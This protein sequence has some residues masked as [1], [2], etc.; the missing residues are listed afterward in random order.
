MKC[1][2]L[3]ASA[4]L[5]QFKL[6]AKPVKSVL[7]RRCAVFVL[8]MTHFL[9]PNL[10]TAQEVIL[11]SAE[12]AAL[13]ISQRQEGAQSIVSNKV[14]RFVGDVIVKARS[15]QGV[16]P[17]NNILVSGNTPAGGVSDFFAL[18][19]GGRPFVHQYY[20]GDLVATDDSTEA[21]FLLG[22][23]SN[24]GMAEVAAMTE[25]KFSDRS[26]PS[27]NIELVSGR[28]RLWIQKE[29]EKGFTV[30]VADHLVV[31][32]GIAQAFIETNGGDARISV[33]EGAVDIS[34]FSMTEKNRKLVLEAQQAV[35]ISNKRLDS[36][37]GPPSGA[38]SD[39]A[40]FPPEENLMAF[41]LP[42]FLGDH[43]N[44]NVSQSFVNGKVG[45]L[46]AFETR[47]FR[48]EHSSIWVD[49]GRIGR[50]HDTSL[51][52]NGVIRFIAPVA[53]DFRSQNSI[54]GSISL[55]WSVLAA[56]KKFSKQRSA[57]Q[58][59]GQ[60]LRVLQFRM[61]SKHVSAVWVD[62]MIGNSSGRFEMPVLVQDGEWQTLRVPIKESGLSL[63]RE[64][65][66]EIDRR[67]S[68]LMRH[69][70]Q[71][72]LDKPVEQIAVEIRD[73]EILHCMPGAYPAE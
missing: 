20:K 56:G 54:L 52:E 34:G 62:Q 38:G 73:F 45:R 7:V 51:T 11:P 3:S 50:S 53:E 66:P 29:V 72:N 31:A 46:N 43:K 19:F 8:H 61:R 30:K 71:T 17:V 6:G 1:I 13:L 12:R 18:G 24:I 63:S 65:K 10:S 37:I 44:Q 60:Y 27:S 16:T 58:V 47:S 48:A 26:E 55:R 21:T 49:T 9:V 22:D 57:Q 33:H 40:R 41:L 25:L 68:L 64:M 39:S 14:S 35:T 15:A 59:D 28:L 2:L 5:Q 4:T 69:R 23:E 67:T 32:R 36:I 42:V 70:P